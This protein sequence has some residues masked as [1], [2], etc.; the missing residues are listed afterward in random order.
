MK[1]RIM[2]DGVSYRRFIPFPQKITDRTLRCISCGQIDEDEIHDEKLCPAC[3]AYDPIA[4][5]AAQKET[6]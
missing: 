5:L 3:G 2:V 1:A 6:T 4:Y